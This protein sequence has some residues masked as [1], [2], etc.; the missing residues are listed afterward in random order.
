MKNSKV[1]NVAMLTTMLLMFSSCTQKMVNSSST[2][3][4]SSSSSSTSTTDSSSSTTISGCD[5]V[6]RS[7]ASTC[8][9]KNLP[10]VTVSGPGTYG[11]TLWSSSTDLSGT[12]LSQNQFVTD[13]T[14]SVRM[15]PSYILDKRT[16]KQGRVC[17]NQRTVPTKVK[18]FVMMRKSTASLG[19]V[20]TLTATYNTSSST[21]DYSNTYRYTVP[22][23]TT[24][25]YVL[26][27]VGV[28]TNQRCLESSPPATCSTEP[29]MDIPV[30]TGTSPTPCIG[31]KLQMATD[32]T[33]D[34]PN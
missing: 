4:S 8:Y 15:V 2:S 20:A 31:F 5:G 12:G 26:E 13:A 9:Y 19:E 23:G 1:K 33:Y 30:V 18:L 24:S 22:G 28:Q 17:T 11:T 25:P 27:V 34:L 21:W 6:Y 16:S 14:F 32:E 10:E 29:Y 7:G 3:T